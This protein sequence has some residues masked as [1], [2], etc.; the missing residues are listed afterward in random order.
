MTTTV[1]IADDHKLFRL[2]LIAILASI[3]QVRVVGE[4][5]NGREAVDLCE[6]LKPD[7]VVMDIAMPEMNG[8]IATRMIRTLCEDTRIL[9]LSMHLNEAYVTECIKSGASAYLLKDS[10]FEELVIAI[11]AVKKGETYLSPAVASA[12]VKRLTSG[13]SSVE[14]SV[15]DLLSP[16]EQEVLQLL[17]EGK[18]SKEMAEILIVSPKTVENHRA[19]IMRKL[20]IHDIPSLV[21]FAIRI[22][23]CEV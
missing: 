1:L 23:L 16:R 19:S 6:R 22:G 20:D 4:A 21:K 10:A 12:V 11:D 2:G 13:G 3:E 8:I 5:G 9:I 18:S 14:T 15:F 17:V 7:L